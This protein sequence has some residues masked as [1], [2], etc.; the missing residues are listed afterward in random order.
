MA[1][2]AR[3]PTSAT[4]P[5][6]EDSDSPVAYSDSG[7]IGSQ[8]FS[9]SPI[10]M[11]LLAPPI[12]PP[13]S[14][15]SPIH[16]IGHDTNPPIHFLNPESDAYAVAG[17]D[18]T[19]T[20]SRPISVISREQPMPLPKDL[21][22]QD[23]NRLSS[24]GATP[25]NY[26]GSV[27]AEVK[28]TDLPPGVSDDTGD[29]NIQSLPR[30]QGKGARVHNS[31]SLSRKSEAL[32]AAVGELIKR[33]IFVAAVTEDYHWPNSGSSSNGEFYVKVRALQLSCNGGVVQQFSQ[34]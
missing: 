2:S 29:K 33:C 21:P 19:L 27:V 24:T 20:K 1:V 5:I 16:D 17:P 9:P 7:S 28:D 30:P 10:P 34:K 22:Q 15:S 25:S 3:R 18:E 11:T 14:S 12:H 4:I 32:S 26:G 8:V 6:Q 31:M 13:F 23:S